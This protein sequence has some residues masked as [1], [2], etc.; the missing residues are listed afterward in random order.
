MGARI[1]RIRFGSRKWII[2]TAAVVVV[3]AGGVTTA[4]LW[5]DGSS[6]ASEAGAVRTLTATVATSTFE[7]SVTATGTLSPTVAED[8]SF[9]A[10]GTV[11]KVKVEEGDTVKKGQVLAKIDTLQL[12]ASLLS[13]KANLAT[14]RADLAD[15]ED[16]DDSSGTDATE[17]QVSAKEAA[18]AVAKASYKEAKSAMSDA[19]LK[20]PV[21][22]LVTA[23][24]IEVGDAVSGSSSSS[25]SSSG[26]SGESGAGAGMSGGS[27]ASATTTAASTTTAF[28][29]TGTDSWTVAAT[30]GESDVANVKAGDQVEMTSDD[31]TDTVFGV[32]ASVGKLP[33]TSSG[34]VSY[35]VTITV[36]GTPD[37]LHDG[38]SVDVT[39]IYE[40]R[41]DVLS[42]PSA[43]V[44]TTDGASTVSVI[45]DDQTLTT[46]TVEVGDTSDSMTEI[47]SGLTAGQTV[48]Y[49]PFT[50]GAG[51]SSSAGTGAD[52]AGQRGGGGMPSGFPGGNGGG[53]AGFGGGAPAGGGNR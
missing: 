41:A 17:A 14:A 23:V 39:I 4:L 21:A 37:G 15:A 44:T 28:S 27:T 49:T 5:P 13:A 53:G 33:S 8:V 51:N 47:T 50:G 12:N 10:S 32:V 22:G 46:T 25:S 1:K 38:I 26:S 16:A 42:V 34:T 3:A 20:A 29:I 35:P 52:D 30:V 2:I 7:K 19:V 24:G 6:S 18:V 11:T 36:T 45:G 9:E 48:S 40:R 31:L 43:A